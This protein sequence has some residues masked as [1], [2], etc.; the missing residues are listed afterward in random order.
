VEIGAKSVKKCE[1]RVL[2]REIAKIMG[3]VA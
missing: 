1:K 2:E 3:E